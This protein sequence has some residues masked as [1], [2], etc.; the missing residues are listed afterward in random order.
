MALSR[1]LLF[2]GISCAVVA[3]LLVLL[4]AISGGI[5]C[6]VTRRNKMLK[7]MKRFDPGSATVAMDTVQTAGE[8]DLVY[9]DV[10][11]VSVEDIC[12]NP[13]YDTAARISGSGLLLDPTSRGV[14][15]GIIPVDENVSY[16][17]TTTV[18]SLNGSRPTGPTPLQEAGSGDV[19]STVAPSFMIVH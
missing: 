8:V 10:D 7:H 18:D 15:D 12:G 14:P 4:L 6:I 3:L 1:S 19:L 9:E 17:I 13:A 11:G 5:L 16:G 2:E